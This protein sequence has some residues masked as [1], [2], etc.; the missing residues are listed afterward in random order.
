[1]EHVE[2]K[3]G[4]KT[5]HF[6][7]FLETPLDHSIQIEYI[8]RTQAIK[9][10]TCCVLVYT[11][12]TTGLSKGAMISHD[13]LGGLSKNFN[14]NMLVPNGRIITFLPTSHIASLSLDVVMAFIFG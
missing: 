13:N 9:P 3:N 7:D 4:V 6:K 8:S 14:E 10:G 2:E 11:S 1:M 12:G 5:I